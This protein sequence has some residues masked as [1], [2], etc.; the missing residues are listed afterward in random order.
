MRTRI[1]A[2]LSDELLKAGNVSGDAAARI[3]NTLRPRAVSR[4]P[5]R[6]F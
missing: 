4:F 2:A 3:Y 5:E 6:K 1:I